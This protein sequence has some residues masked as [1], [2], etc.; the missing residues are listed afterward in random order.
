MADFCGSCTLQQKQVWKKHTTQQKVN[1]EGSGKHLFPMLFEDCVSQNK[2]QPALI[3]LRNSLKR[4][5][6]K[7]HYCNLMQLW[8]YWV[9]LVTD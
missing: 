2:R 3:N 8:N 7:G 6:V 1:L 9:E 5:T 4:E